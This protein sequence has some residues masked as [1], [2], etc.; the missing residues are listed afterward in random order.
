MDEEIEGGE[1]VKKEEREKKIFLGA[2][3]T[4]LYRILLFLGLNLLKHQTKLKV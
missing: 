1:G 2:E 4:L 3:H